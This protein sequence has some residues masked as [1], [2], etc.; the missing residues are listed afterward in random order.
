MRVAVGERRF[1]GRAIDLGGTGVGAAAVERAIRRDGAAAGADFPGEEEEEDEET[2][3]VDCPPPGPVHA[4]VCSVR[5][6]MTVGLTGALAA[7]ARTR[8]H[9]AP[10]ERALRTAR[11]RL[12]DLPRPDVDLTD[13]RRRAAT[14]G[15][16]E[17][18]LEERVA[19]LRGRVQTLREQDG[20]SATRAETALADAVRELTDVETARHAARQRL[21]QAESAA[22]EARDARERRLCLEDRVGNLERSVR[23]SLA[24]TVHG[25]FAAAVEQLPGEGT[26]GE[27]PASYAG[28]DVTAALAVIRVAR[29]DAPVVLDVRRFGS[30]GEAAT[31]LRAPV[32]RT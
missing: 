10:D 24:A 25:A 9:S 4:R 6:E 32:I 15:E 1:R 27:D 8:G 16:S 26:A 12:A 18:R 7:A 14:A 17:R 5:P 19:T 20:A 29:V 22:R 13:V 28:D 11:E 21:R 31:R 23:R 2:V 3:R 30:A